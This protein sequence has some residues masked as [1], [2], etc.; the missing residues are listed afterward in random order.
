MTVILKLWDFL[1]FKRTDDKYDQ[2]AHVKGHD[3]MLSKKP[4]HKALYV[5]LFL[6]LLFFMWMYGI[7]SKQEFYLSDIGRSASLVFISLAPIAFLWSKFV[8]RCGWLES[9]LI[10]FGVLIA[11]VLIFNIVLTTAYGL[12]V[13]MT[14]IEGNQTFLELIEGNLE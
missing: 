6:L 14:T 7:G 13:M 1:K 10:S 11:A 12:V 3:L 2:F 9:G 5:A 4:N 8:S